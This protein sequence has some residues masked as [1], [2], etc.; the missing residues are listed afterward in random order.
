MNRPVTRKAIDGDLRAVPTDKDFQ[1]K[2]IDCEL[3]V[4][5]AL[6][7]QVDAIWRQAVQ[8]QEKGLFDGTLLSVLAVS[9][10]CV[11]V[12]Q[13]QYRYYYAQSQETTLF[14]SL[15]VRP[16]ACSGILMCPEGLVMARRGSNVFLDTSKWELAPSGTMDGD[17]I[18]LDG[19]INVSNFILREMNEELGIIKSGRS[20]LR[21]SESAV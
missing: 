18:G 3:E 7:T 9:P 21:V 8:D 17:S 12:Y 13:T 15:N 19:T 4:E 20:L 14:E 6:Q 11:E 16:L 2:L 5:A 10:Q 1:V